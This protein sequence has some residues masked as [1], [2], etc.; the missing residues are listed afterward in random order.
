M[1]RKIVLWGTNEQDEKI[2]VA[3]ELIDAENK[4]D[5]Y[6]FKQDVATEEFYN[7]MLNEWR[8]D[9]EVEL[10]EHTKIE[11][12]L[13]VSDSILPDH[14]KVDRTDLVTRAQT[15]WHFVVL[16]AKLYQMYKS[17]VEDISD[18]V[19]TLTNFDNE[20]WNELK[21][22]W[23]K[24]Q[25]Q[26]IERNLFREHAS[27]LKN[28]TN[29]L[30]SKLKEMKKAFE[31]EYEANSSKHKEDLLNNLNEIKDRI[32]KGLGLK[33]LFEEL[34]QL[35]RKVKDIDFTKKHRRQVWDQIDAAF[36]VVKEKRFGDQ[37]GKSNSGNSPKDRLQRR[38]NGLLSAIEKM[39]KSIKRDK[40]DQEW[41]SKRANTTN[42][43]LE[44]Q[45]RQAKIKM[46]EERIASKGVKLD[47]MLKTK[48]DL[49]KK[50]KKEEEREAKRKEQA[51]VNKA[52]AKAAEA[53]K[54]KIAA[55]IKSNTT[56]DET[57]AKLEKAASQIA[58]SKSKIPPVALPQEGEETQ[59]EEESKTDT[60][61]TEE[62]VGKIMDEAQ[63]TIEEV[64][65][66]VSDV[67]SALSVTIS[68]TIEDVVDTVRAVAQ[69]VE[70]KIEDIT[71]EE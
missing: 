13:T 20:V 58:E 9:K 40:D 36:K 29:D 7:A 65:D 69:V 60:S 62:A 25:E 64:K 10:A 52:K 41:Q 28:K 24:V 46:I 32:D 21:G 34:K 54:A 6:T 19:E 30:F 63:E 37:E 16:S 55:D 5:V 59:A 39:K 66:Q 27:S 43:Q 51:E 35:Q 49:E 44:M 4:V 8:N 15:E 45:I 33:P 26:V 31:K 70:D 47:D 42:G 18:R 68:E 71:E 48:V 56:D 17:E 1:R 14:I 23:G 12:P 67:F 50:I 2:L 3:L 38:Y 22:F 11:R 57:K 53:A 61:A